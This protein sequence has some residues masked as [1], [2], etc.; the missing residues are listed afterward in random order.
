MEAGC[1]T[2]PVP[3][4]GPRVDLTGLLDLLG[5]RR[6]TNVLVEGGGELLGGLF[7][8]GLVDRVM[9][10]VAP[11][12][13]GSADAATPVGGQGAAA[14]SEALHL[15]DAETDTCGPDACIRGWVTDPLTWAP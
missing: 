13:I 10:F 9:A 6:M 14:V 8:G 5:A 4:D 12:I 11:V 3:G 7:D 1:E 2:L 15:R